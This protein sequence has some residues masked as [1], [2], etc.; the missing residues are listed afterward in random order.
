MVTWKKSL[1]QWVF[2]LSLSLWISKSLNREEYF[3]N[4]SES[5]LS[6]SV[7]CSLCVYFTQNNAK[8]RLGGKNDVNRFSWVRNA[9]ILVSSIEVHDCESQCLG[10]QLLVINSRGIKR[11]SII[12]TGYGSH[13]SSLSFSST[14]TGDTDI[15]HNLFLKMEITLLCIVDERQKTFPYF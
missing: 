14:E 3:N 8:R 12:T 11:N 6:P 1:A 4:K 7:S 9:R 5:S 10:H 13:S 2:F 15:W